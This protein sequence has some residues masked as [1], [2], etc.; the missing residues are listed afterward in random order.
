MTN[1]KKPVG[2]TLLGNWVEER[3]V[4]HLI[5]AEQDFKKISRNGHKVTSCDGCDLGS[6]R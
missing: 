4:A 2:A 1:G 5:V 6:S 3:S